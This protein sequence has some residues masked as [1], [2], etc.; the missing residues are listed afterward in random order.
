LPPWIWGIAV[1]LAAILAAY[2][3]GNADPLSTIGYCGEDVVAIMLIAIFLIY[4]AG[5]GK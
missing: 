1:L 4:L 5:R 3:V 2:A